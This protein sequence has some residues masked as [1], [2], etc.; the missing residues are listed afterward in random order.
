MIMSEFTAQRAN[1]INKMNIPEIE[2]PVSIRILWFDTLTASDVKNRVSAETHSHSFFEIHFVFS[3]KLYY[4]C[5]GVAAELCEHQAL[6]IS[7]AVPHKYVRYSKDLCKLSVAFSFLEN[8]S[9][10]RIF[11]DIK[12]K[13][14]NF[15]DDVTENVNFILKQS[16]KRDVFVPRLISGRILEIIYSVCNA[17]QMRLPEIDDRE[18]DSRVIVAKEYIANNRH[19]IINCE[20]VA[21]ECCL[22]S[23]QLNRVFKSCTGSSV[24]EYIISSRIKYA[25]QL[26][27]QNEY[28]IKEISFMMGFEDEC[29]FV[30]FFKRHCGIPPGSFRKMSEK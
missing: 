28:S 10:S 7:P 30:S 24:F 6:L 8:N 3:G 16:D 18:C 11:N 1:A 12:F 25:K 20:D 14:L 4:E 15:S 23:K 21:K 29:G 19:R 17:L 27:L 22:S 5:D 13:K 2:L 9:L 26:L